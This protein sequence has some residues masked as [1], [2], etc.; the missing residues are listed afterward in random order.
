MDQATDSGADPLQSAGSS[1]TEHGPKVISVLGATGSVG[2]SSLDIISSSPDRYRVGAVT[3]NGNVEKLAQIAIETKAGFAAVADEQCLDALKDAL[4]GTG[5]AVGAGEAGLAEAAAWPA[6]M[7]VGAIVG[8]AGI[9]PTMAALEAGNQ[10]ALANKEALV[11]AGDLVMDAARRLGKPILPV[12]SEHSAIFQIFDDANRD[13]IE[14]VTITASG[15]PFRTWAQGDI[16]KATPEQALNHPNWSMGAKV[17]IDSAS[18]MNKG[19][20]VIEAHHLYDMPLEKLKVIVHPQSIIHGLVTY[21]DGS[22]L[23][24]LGAADM[25]IPVAHCLAWP[26]RA[27][28]NTRRISLVEIAQLTFEAPDMA[29]FPCLGL[30]LESLRVGGNL[31]NIMN[32]ANEVAVAAF[33][34]HQLPFGGIAR[35]VEAVMDRFVQLGEV[36]PVGSVDAV[37]ATDAAARCVADEVRANLV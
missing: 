28:A 18:L 13:E 8:A 19:L 9:R 15:G 11:C 26:Q 25:R 23:A 30:A 10:V 4:S 3:A 6:D 33:L 21:S 35:M 20:E 34:D 22:M 37:L 12:D 1:A 2:D 32:A 5:I 24:H 36:G 17:T 7:V 16:E 27:A 14:D 29:R 31:P